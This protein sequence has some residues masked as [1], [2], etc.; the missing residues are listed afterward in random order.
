MLE[1]QAD[2][3]IPG[4]RK[5]LDQVGTSRKGLR[6]GADADNLI[7]I[8]D[9]LVA[10]EAT[11]ES[12][13]PGW[14]CLVLRWGGQGF[15]FNR[16]FPFRHTKRHDANSAPRLGSDTNRPALDLLP[17]EF[18][19]FGQ[20]GVRFEFTPAG[21][22][23][24]GESSVCPIDGQVVTTSYHGVRSALLQSSLARVEDTQGVQEWR[25]VSAKGL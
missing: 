25:S 3:P 1:I 9:V 4:R 14:A 13:S 16:F 5:A 10:C 20:V 8:E 6:P 24:S 11:P 7:G 22:V 2:G 18:L 17:D 21:F 12:H 19:D 23:C 15:H